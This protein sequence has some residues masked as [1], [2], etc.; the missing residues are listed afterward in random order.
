[1]ELRGGGPY[2]RNGGPA[3]KPPRTTIITWLAI[4]IFIVVVSLFR[5]A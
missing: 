2:V 1:M 5:L 4:A 3:F